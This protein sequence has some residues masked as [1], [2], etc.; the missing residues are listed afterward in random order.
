MPPAASSWAFAFSASSLL[1]LSSTGFGALSTRS[2][3]SFRPRLVR[4]RTSL[5][6]WIF[7]SPAEVRTTLNSLFSSSAAG[8][9]APPPAGAGGH[10]H[11][12]R[13]R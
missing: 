6:T 2:L 3:A 5:M 1:T 8:A 10:R 4:E 13:P 11:R 7:L 9:S 12:E